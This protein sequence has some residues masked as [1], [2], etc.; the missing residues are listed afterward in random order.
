[1]R[2]SDW[3]SDV[4]SADLAA[5]ACRGC[6]GSLENSPPT[7]AFQLATPRPSEREK[8][9]PLV[10]S[11]YDQSG[12]APASSSTLTTPRSRSEERSVGKEGVS[13]CGFRWSPYH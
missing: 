9:C 3:S 2:I 6:A 10:V 11:E 1:M 7:N 4:C 5:S 8:R 12:P 13:T